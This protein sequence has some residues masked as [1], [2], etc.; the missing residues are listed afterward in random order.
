M[1][2]IPIPKR[3][4]GYAVGYAD[5]LF[6][7]E[8]FMDLQCPF[9]KKAW[10]TLLEVYEFYGEEK[11]RLTIQPMVLANHRQSWDVTKAAIAT[12][13]D[14]AHKFIDFA[15]YLYQHQQ[16]YRNSAFKERTQVDLH[17]LLA[18]YAADG[19]GWTDKVAFLERLESDEIYNE[20]R[21]PCRLAAIR[22]VWST[23]TFFINGAEAVG[24]SS[25]SSRQ[26]WQSIL[27][28]LLA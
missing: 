15:S 20:T 27:D 19:A 26:D 25:D 28:P 7:I 12:A 14:N 9:S 18:D 16:D 21:V 3:P 1:T 4:S 5:A 17:H 24:L 23:P 8:L 11:I 22:G 6:Q 10:S 13:E 2:P